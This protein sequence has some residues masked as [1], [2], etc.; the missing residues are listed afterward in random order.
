MRSFYRERE[1]FMN[2]LISYRHLSYSSKSKIVFIAL[3][4]ALSCAEFSYQSLSVNC[5][6]KKQI[7]IFCHNI[8]LLIANF[9]ILFM[10][11]FREFLVLIHGS[12]LSAQF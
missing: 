4:K 2:L 6:A 7:W 8:L 3:V 5:Q 9:C 11:K 10:E 1:A 12:I